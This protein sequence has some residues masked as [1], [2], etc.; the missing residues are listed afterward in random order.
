IID[1]TKID[2]P[3]RLKKHHL[4]KKTSQSVAHLHAGLERRSELLPDV[5]CPEVFNGQ[6][7]RDNPTSNV[8]YLV[9]ISIK[10]R[11]QRQAKR[12]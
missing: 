9:L 8:Y 4:F 2:H 7:D 10:Q 12:F 1:S 11:H 3:I 6:Y 5:F